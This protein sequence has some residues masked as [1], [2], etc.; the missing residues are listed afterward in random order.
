MTAQ[1]KTPK[2]T[3]D[4]IKWIKK[5]KQNTDRLK[6]T[7]AMLFV[8]VISFTM[9]YTLMFGI[10]TGKG[11]IMGATLLSIIFT[12]AIIG[13]FGIDERYSDFSVALFILSILGLITGM[14]IGNANFA[15]LANL[16]NYPISIQASYHSNTGNI[17]V[18]QNCS[19]FSVSASGYYDGYAINPV[20]ST[21][22]N[23]PKDIANYS[24]PFD[25]VI[26]STHEGIYC[27]GNDMSNVVW[28]GKILNISKRVVK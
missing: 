24:N 1:K 27:M 16:I 28:N 18:T 25:C 12:L 3:S 15:P 22:C 13:G 17:T 21:E 5:H 4:D 9:S 26:N 23:L 11:W 2:L 7:F 10:N 20:N 19:N 14:I 8:I 6:E